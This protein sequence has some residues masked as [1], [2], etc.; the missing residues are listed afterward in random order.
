MLIDIE[1]DQPVEKKES[2]KFSEGF[3]DLDFTKKSMERVEVDDQKDSGIVNESLILECE[4]FEESTEVVEFADFTAVASVEDDIVN[5]AE[6]GIKPEIVVELPRQSSTTANPNMKSD[7]DGTASFATNTIA[8]DLEDFSSKRTDK[9]DLEPQ[10]NFAT[11]P[12]IDL[13]ETKKASHN[14]SLESSPT[15]KILS[16]LNSEIPLASTPLQEPLPRESMTLDL[17]ENEETE[18]AQEKTKSQSLVEHKSW[19]SWKSIFCL[20]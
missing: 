15:A 18:V 9:D 20:K 13:L 2:I 3:L 1:S 4:R 7:T 5:S 6:I 10:E 12:S 16:D 14:H 19:W 17:H 11:F 8:L